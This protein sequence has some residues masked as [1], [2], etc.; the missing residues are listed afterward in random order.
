MESQ[1]SQFIRLLEMSTTNVRSIF[2]NL[3]INNSPSYR[4]WYGTKDRCYNE[5]YVE[6]EYYGGRGIT[7]CGR[8]MEPEGVGFINF[9]E[10]MGER[11]EGMT[12]D[13]KDPN[14][15]YEPENCK[16]SSLSEQS[17]NKRKGI[18]NTTGKVGVYKT[19]QC[20]HYTAMI[21]FQR[22]LIYLG[23]FIEFLDAVYAREVAELEY[24]GYL[25]HGSYFSKEEYND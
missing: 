16:W 12:L 17:F 18:N 10:D 21:G 9:L 1:G 5:N 22:E 20:G 14:G 6:Y 25:K 19:K 11:P 13:R 4:S 7:V 23:Y 24:F 2:S 3:N 15:N 8:W